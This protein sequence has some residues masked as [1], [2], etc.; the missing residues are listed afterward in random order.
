MYIIPVINTGSTS[1][2]LAVYGYTMNTGREEEIEELDRSILKAPASGS[3]E[4]IDFLVDYGKRKHQ[5]I[6]YFDNFLLKHKGLKVGGI[7]ARGGLLKPLPGG[8]YKIDKK[9]VDD[10]LECRYGSHPSNMSAPIAFELSKKYGVS[11]FIAYPVVTDEMDRI[12][13]YT[14]FPEIKRKSIFHALN[15]KAVSRYVSR[16]LGRAYEDLRIIVC[17]MG[18]G[19][20]VGLH[21]NGKVV[22]VNNAL[23]GEGP[24]SIER[25]GTLPAGDLVKYCFKTPAVDNKMQVNK[26]Q[27]SESQIIRRITKESGIY[28]YLGIKDARMIGESINKGKGLGGVSYN[29]LLEIIEAFAYRI[30]K[31]ICSLGAYLGEKLDVIILTGG[32]SYFKY[33]TDKIV[34][35]VKFMSERIMIYPGENELRALAEYVYMAI[36]GTVKIMYYRS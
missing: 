4:S 34:G 8:V 22:D 15:Q 21:V 17:H 2:K 35:R 20:S 25:A 33:L 5:I 31:E 18:G 3:K 12:A 11:S 14:G 7:A 29:E 24:F 1:T 36:V 26:L 10:L 16:E 28:A 32:L 13:K 9:M 23:D 30:S 27:I 6:G 19:I